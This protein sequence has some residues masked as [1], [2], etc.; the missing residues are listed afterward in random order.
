MKRELADL[1]KQIS[2]SEASADR[3]RNRDRHGAAG[4]SQI[5]LVKRE[6]EQMLDYKRRDLRNLEE[7][8][9]GVED[10]KSLKSVRE[11]LEMVKEQVDALEQ[12]LRRREDVLREVLEEVAQEKQGRR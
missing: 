2:E 11:D 8:S 9:G 1:E 10:G 6:L 4:A 12:H 7:G 5:A 3:R